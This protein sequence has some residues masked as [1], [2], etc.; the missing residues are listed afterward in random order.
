MES[1]FNDIVTSKCEGQLYEVTLK[2]KETQT[3]YKAYQ[4]IKKK[5][6]TLELHKT[7]ATLICEPHKTLQL[8]SIH[9][10]YHI[11]FY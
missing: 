9:F 10:I 6:Y 1:K 5:I 3:Y 2:K 11:Y 8:P 7:Q 4:H